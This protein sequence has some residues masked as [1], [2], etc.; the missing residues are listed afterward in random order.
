MFCKPRGDIL[1]FL[2]AGTHLGGTN[3]DF[4]MEQ[5]TYKRKSDSVYSINLKRTWEK[6]LLAARAIVD[7]E[8]P[9]VV[10]VTSSKN[11]GQLSS[12][13]CGHSQ[14]LQQQEGSLSGSDVVDGGLRSTAYAC[15]H[16]HEHLWE[17]MPDLCFYK[18]PRGGWKE[19]AGHAEMAVTKEVFKGEWAAPSP[20]CPAAQ[21]EVTGTSE[22]LQCPL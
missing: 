11:T 6:L 4:Q 20:E 13:L 7:I 16:P 9:A 2:A 18:R 5:Y 21:P 22:G 17:V 8:H 12:V 15:H 19:R 3:L 14:P 10:S 1:K